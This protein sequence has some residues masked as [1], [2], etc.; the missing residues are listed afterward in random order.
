MYLKLKIQTLESVSQLKE[1]Q[2]QENTLVEN[3]KFL[4]V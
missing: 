1:P 2:N 3:S 4:T